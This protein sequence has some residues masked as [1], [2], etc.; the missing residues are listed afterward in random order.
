MTNTKQQL[1]FIEL[2]ISNVHTKIETM[3]TANKFINPKR[4]KRKAK[5]VENMVIAKFKSLDRS[6][7]TELSMKI[8]ESIKDEFEKDGLTV[9][10]LDDVDVS[11]MGNDDDDFSNTQDGVSMMV[12][13]KVVAF[14]D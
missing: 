11:V 6:L 2:L 3:M 5:T 13:W 14:D 1:R 10:T 12:N 7:I 8:S 4:S 9:R